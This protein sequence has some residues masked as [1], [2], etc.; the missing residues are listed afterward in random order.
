MRA[1]NTNNCPVGIATQRKNLRARLIV[2]EAAQR[3]ARFFAASVELMGVLARACGHESL[4]EFCLDDLTTFDREMRHLA[5][6]A[7]GGVNS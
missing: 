3:L 6:I 5:G 1:C 4:S 7:Y 2:D